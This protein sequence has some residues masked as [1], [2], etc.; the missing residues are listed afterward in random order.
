MV[1]LKLENVA[2][3]LLGL[4]QLAGSMQSDGRP[5]GGSLFGVALRSQ[6]VDAAGSVQPVIDLGFALEPLDVPMV[7]ARALR[8]DL[9]VILCDSLHLEG[10]A[11]RFRF[12]HAHNMG[13]IRPNG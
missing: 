9:P 4:G 2:V 12:C 5:G 11:G 1:G 3:E 6:P 10:D 7:G 8:F 13:Q